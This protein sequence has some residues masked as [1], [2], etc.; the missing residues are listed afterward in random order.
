MDYLP[1]IVFEWTESAV[2]D[3]PAD[4]DWRVY[5][6]SI[7]ERVSVEV[8]LF[9]PTVLGQVQ[10]TVINDG[11]AVQVLV[12][13]PPSFLQSDQLIAEGAIASRVA[14]RQ[15]TVRQLINQHHGDVKFETIIQLPRRCE[16]TFTD[17]NVYGDPHSAQPISIGAYKSG[18]TPRLLPN[19]SPQNMFIL[20]LELVALAS[21]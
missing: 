5:Y 19:M 6:A 18:Y 7:R 8:L 14:A 1:Y 13:P 10:A 12:Q 15:A 3:K 21:Y 2:A 16:H 4:M 17:R 11:T 9:G 20:H